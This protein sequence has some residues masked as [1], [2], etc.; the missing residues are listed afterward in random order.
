M[1]GP[2]Y[3]KF[4]EVQF[5]RGF[6][7]TFGVGV[8]PSVCRISTVP[9]TTSLRQNGDLTLHTVGESPLVFRDCLLES[10]RLD[11]GPQGTYWQLPILDRRWRWRFAHLF[12]SYNVLRPDGSYLREKTPQELA[13]ILLDAMGESGYDVSRLPNDVRPAARW[14]EGAD[15]AGELDRLCNSL[16]CV[17]VL[18]WQ[19]NRVEI[20]P[21]GDGDFLP[22]GAISGRAYAP[23]Q[24]ARPGKLRADAGPTLFQDIFTTQA[25]G[26]DT[27]GTWKHIN[28]LSYR[29]PSGRWPW[30]AGPDPYQYIPGTSQV[31]VDGVPTK[32]RSLANSTIFRCYRVT[33]LLSGGWVPTHMALSPLQP[34]SLRDYRL[35]AS[36]VDEEISFDD[37]G[38]RQLPARVY[39]QYYRPTPKRLTRPEVYPYG[40]HLD[41]TQGIVRF[42]EPVFRSVAGQAVPATVLLETGFNAGA[43]GVMH[44]LS[45]ER[46]LSASSVVHAIEQPSTSL[47]VRQRYSSLDGAGTPE[48]ITNLADANAYL[49]HWLDSAEREYFSQEGGTLRYE[50]LVPLKLDGKTL[51]VSWSGGGGR[52]PITVASQAQRHNRYVKPPDEYRDR[53][54]AAKAN[55][56]IDQVVARELGGVLV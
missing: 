20:W 43:D 24:A 3:A 54:I 28:S 26:L 31:L 14:E 16:S 45:A 17:V 27:D 9:H 18:N 53:L 2:T 52:G 41:T 6:D 39:A 21:I 48:A 8:E 7:F 34:S 42:N 51:Q 40:F 29:P 38:L 10:P 25:V 33:G 32:V 50:Q 5:S 44:R 37:G 1:P 15:A 19:S 56:A 12:G 46:V 55:R 36:L 35:Y 4:G 23:V 30:P 11:V 13:A 47:R 22:D 49:G